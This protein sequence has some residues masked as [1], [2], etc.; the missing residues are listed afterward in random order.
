MSLARYQYFLK[1]CDIQ[2][3]LVSLGLQYIDIKILQEN[4]VQK[5]K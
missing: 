2:G 1:S 4:T 5:T 3:F